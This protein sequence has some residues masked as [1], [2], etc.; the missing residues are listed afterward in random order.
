MERHDVIIVGAGISGLSFAYECE[1]ADIDYIVLESSQRVG[2]SIQSLT[3]KNGH[4]EQVPLELGAHT[5]FNN[6]EKCIDLIEELNIDFKKKKKSKIFF[7]STKSSLL[8]ESLLKRFQFFDA[9]YCFLR[10]LLKSF[11][12]KENSSSISL[13][14]KLVRLIGE[15]NFQRVASP[16][17][18]ALSNQRVENIPENVFFKSRDRKKNK[19]YPRRFSISGGNENLVKKLAENLNVSLNSPVDKISQADGGF[20]CASIKNYS[21]KYVVLAVPGNVLVQYSE[22][23]NIESETLSVT[24]NT[25]VGETDEANIPSITVFD[26]S[27]HYSE[28]VFENAPNFTISHSNETN[29]NQNNLFSKMNTL[30]KLDNLGRI[31]AQA[32]NIFLV[33]NY[34]SGMSI[35]DC[36]KHSQATFQ[37]LKNKLRN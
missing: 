15:K 9:I 31:T 7:R 10:S 18:K 6:Y 21:C 19:H 4:N 23:L 32:D 34:F 24:F 30:P 17:L 11:F 5:L 36:I 29:A 26:E 1:K 33:G 2:G 35:E 37:I 27:N 16:A 13:K 25:Q 3:Q 8:S 22:V 20:K 12:I 14:E 28:I